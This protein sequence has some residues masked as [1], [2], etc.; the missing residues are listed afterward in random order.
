MLLLLE[1]SQ[2]GLL[3]AYIFEKWAGIKTLASGAV[4]GALISCLMALSYD[5]MIHGTTNWMSWGGVFMD[6]I[7]FSL[8][9]AV[10]GA[11]AGF[12]L[13]YKRAL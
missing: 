4:S 11:F 3:L 1:I 9:G 7:V 5:S 6:V 10:A 12:T 8:C 13:G 2:Q